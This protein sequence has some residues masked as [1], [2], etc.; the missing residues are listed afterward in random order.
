VFAVRRWRYIRL[1]AGQRIGVWICVILVIVTIAGAG[2]LAHMRPIVISLAEARVNNV[3]SRIVVA[4]INEAVDKGVINYDDLVTLDKD[5]SGR[6]TA[7]RSNM[8]AVNRI[9]AAVED[10]ILLRLAEVPPSELSV[11]LGTL[12]GSTLLA[13]RGPLIRVRMQTAGS[14][15]AGFRNEFTAAGINQTK[16]QILLHVDVYTGILLPGLTASTRVDHEIAVAETVIVGAVPE[17]YTHFS[18]ADDEIEDYAKEY[19]MNNG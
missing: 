8:S 15:T 5:D 2:L 6:V 14:V 11:P 18:T 3:V 19:V 16:H 17:S 13:G 10:D 7:L 9:L 12:T 1:S 4:S